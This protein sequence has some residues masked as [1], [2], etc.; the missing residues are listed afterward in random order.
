MHDSKQYKVFSQ[1]V[2]HYIYD[3]M[4]NILWKHILPASGGLRINHRYG[5]LVKSKISIQDWNIGLSSLPN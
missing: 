4:L 1:K 3:V 5:S 2:T